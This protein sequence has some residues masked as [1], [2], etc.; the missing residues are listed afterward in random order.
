MHGA[1]FAI[2]KHLNFDVARRGQ[3]FLDIDFVVAKIRFAFGA[4]GHKGAFHV[5]GGLRDFHA[6]ATA[7]SRGFDDHRIADFFADALGIFQRWYTAVRPRHA[8]HAQFFHGV[9]GGDLVAHDA[10]MR[11]SGTDEGQAMVF[12]NLNK[13]SVF[14]Q[15][16]ISGVDCLGSGDFAG[17]NDGRDRQIGLLRRR[18]ADADRFVSHA[19][20]H[21][22]AVSGGMYRYRPD[23]HFARGADHAQRD[24][25]PVGDKDFIKHFQRLIPGSPR[26][27]QI[28]RQHHHRPGY[29]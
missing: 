4:G 10:D 3:I 2:A 19:H 26:G 25:S 23:A 5:S 15:K 28:R 16:P 17:G 1:A 20:V 18:W 24:L 12:E 13:A 14:R 22:V 21:R 8:G 6:L 9:L 11:S 27:H 29:A 7:A